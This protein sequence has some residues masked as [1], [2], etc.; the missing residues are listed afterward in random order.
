MITNRHILIVDDNESIHQ[1]IEAIL[2]S[3]SDATD[4]QLAEMESELFGD[5]EVIRNSEPIQY[6]IDHAYQG[7]EGFEKVK[8]AEEDGHPYSL[9]YM[10]VRMPPGIDGI[11]AIQKIWGKYP[12]VE[13]VIS[14]AYSDYS[15]DQIIRRLGTSDKLLFMKK[16]FDATALK[17]AALTLTTKWQ[18]QQEANQYTEKLEYEVAKRTRQLENFMAD[19][20][21]MKEKAEKASEAKSSFL[22]EMSHEI[23]TPMN[24]LLGMN[25]LLL[26]TDLSEEQREYTEMAKVSAETLLKIIN[27]ILDFSKIEAGKMEL[28]A[29]PFNLSDIVK[30]LSHLI[31]KSNTG[32]E[33]IFSSNTDKKIPATLIGDPVR[34]R[35]ILL[36][37][38]TN[39]L[40]FTEEGRIS[41]N[42]ELLAEDSHTVELKFSVSDTGMGISA[43]DKYKLFE[44][45]SQVNTFTSRNYG[46]SGLGLSICKQLTQLMGGEVGVESEV[47]KGSTF[48]FTAILKKVESNGHPVDV[49][50]DKK[51]APQPSSPATGKILIA[52]DDMGNQVLFKNILEKENYIVDV[53]D[54]GLTVIEAIEHTPYRLILMDLQMP[55]VDGLQ[56]TAAI[57]K[58]EK[59]TGKSIPIIALTGS[60]IK[61]YKSLGFDDYVLKPMKKNH[62]L[63]IIRKWMDK[64]SVQS[65]QPQ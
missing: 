19:Y 38:G 11:Q 13:V 10:D 23:R 32:K 5:T 30:T 31:E 8:K 44:K 20:K 33:I 6:E 57:R 52:E 14:T 24:G 51:E 48:W 65:S 18:L 56:A 59:N 3:P 17:Q 7:E 58:K 41:F 64:E 43:D 25:E 53:A 63:Q 29:V 27:D 35:Q 55:K 9:I 36:N 42:V 4:V 28:E 62:L 2:A 49:N 60:M 46:G 34:I 16:P 54:N 61:D 15:W 26:D 47:D 45:F 39:A 22:A 40:K 37:Y 1:D 50:N 21:K 12:H